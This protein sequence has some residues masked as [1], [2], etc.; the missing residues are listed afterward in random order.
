MIEDILW[1]FVDIVS[2]QMLDN[3]Y[4]SYIFWILFILGVIYGLHNFIM[5]E[6]ELI[7][8][9]TK[10]EYIVIYKLKKD[11]NF[12]EFIIYNIILFLASIILSVFI[13]A[14]VGMF[15]LSLIIGGI[16]ASLVLLKYTINLIHYWLIIPVIFIII[17][18]I[19]YKISL[20]YKKEIKK[21]RGKKNES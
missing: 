15:V 19:L 5:S 1:Q 18:F 3:K 12:L 9:N 6:I 8:R 4:F 2:N 21:K 16:L 13:L 7:K 10:Y 20:K 17:K 11:Y 14:F